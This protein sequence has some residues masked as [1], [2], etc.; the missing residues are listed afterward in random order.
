MTQCASREA[1]WVQARLLAAVA[2]LRFGNFF[3]L[4]FDIRAG[5]VVQQHFIFGSKEILPALLQ[6]R[7]QSWTMFQQ[8]IEHEVKLILAAPSKAGARAIS[9]RRSASAP[10]SSNGK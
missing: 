10:S 9:R 8:T 4:A 1:L 5:Q 7:E 6:M 3:G 2:E